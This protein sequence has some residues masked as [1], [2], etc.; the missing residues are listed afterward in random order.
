MALVI[1]HEHRPVEG[2]CRARLRINAGGGQVVR[3]GVLPRKLERV[4]ALYELE[5]DIAA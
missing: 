4:L 1:A 5:S 3:V 2:R